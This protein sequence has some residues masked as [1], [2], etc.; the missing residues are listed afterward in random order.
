MPY[1]KVAYSLSS[2]VRFVPI[3]HDG[4]VLMETFN[5]VF[6]RAHGMFFERKNNPYVITLYNNRLHPPPDGWRFTVFYP[7]FGDEDYDDDYD[8]ED[9]EDYDEEYFEH[10]GKNNGCGNPPE[11]EDVNM[12]YYHLLNEKHADD[13]ESDDDDE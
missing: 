5:S 12:L 8:E 1:I 9:N 2:P 11:V 6:P 3:E 10:D 4:T 7:I 13:V